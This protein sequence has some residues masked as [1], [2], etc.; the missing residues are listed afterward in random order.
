MKVENISVRQFGVLVILYTIGTTILIIPSGLATLTRQDAWIASIL[1][2]GL[3]MLLVLFYNN[4]SRRFPDMTLVQYSEKILG[5][6]LGKLVSLFF[7]FFSFIGAATVLFYMGNF[8]TTE[9]MSET[10]IQAI[11]V[12]YAMIVVMGLRLGL[13][14]LARAG[15]ILFPWVFA[16]FFVLAVS[17]LPEIQLYKV[18]PVFEAGGK[19]LLYAALSVTGTASL[20][21]IVLFMIFPV[22]VNDNQKARKVFIN[23]TL[24]GGIYFV[25]I[26]F[27]CI[28]VLGADLT[29]N[30]LYPSYALAKII[31]IGQFF[32]RVEV[33]IAA[34]WF[35]TVYYKTTFYFYGFVVGIAQV[36][37]LSDYRPLVLPCGMI[38]VVY[39]LVVYPNVVYAAKFD[40]MVWIPFVMTF[41]LLMPCILLVIDALRRRKNT[42]S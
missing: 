39:S 6:W 7:I 12:L 14:T 21:F 40:S 42:K 5:K 24:T 3:N 9:V 10:P 27:L 1:G 33:L 29:A 22:N 8:I 41:G 20:P 30:H 35:I 16:I 13:E 17:L 28:T 31:N 34:I 26:T 4:L 36:C 11:N 25:V 19:Q 38:L 2:L 37:N 32:Q 18:Q 15:E 23:A